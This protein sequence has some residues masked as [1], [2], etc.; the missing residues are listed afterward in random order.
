MAAL[1]SGSWSGSD[2]SSGGLSSSASPVEGSER[3][4]DVV[5][6]EA[7]GAGVDE[8]IDDADGCASLGRSERRN[9]ADP[10]DESAQAK[11]P[12]LRVFFK[13]RMENR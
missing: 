7:R 1:A 4:A 12:N 3:G 2:G 6:G 13:K 5:R 10:G 9:G 11:Q 8:V